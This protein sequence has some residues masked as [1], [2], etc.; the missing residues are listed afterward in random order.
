MK[1]GAPRALLADA[2]APRR[3]IATDATKNPERLIAPE[4]NKAFNK[5]KAKGCPS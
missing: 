2:I 1:A 5:A 3:S 4:P